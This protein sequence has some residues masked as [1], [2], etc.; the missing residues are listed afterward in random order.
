M[1]LRSRLQKLRDERFYVPVASFEEANDG[2]G[3]DDDEVVQVVAAKT[4][5]YREWLAGRP[6]IPGKGSVAN[7]F[8]LQLLGGGRPVEVLDVG[9]ACGGSCFEARTWFP[10]G[11]RRWHVVEMPEMAAAARP[12]EDEGLRFFSDFET[13]LQGFTEPPIAFL[14]GCLQYMRDPLEVL[15]RL[16]SDVG[17]LWITRTPLGSCDDRVGYFR[18]RTR[19]VDHGPGPAPSGT[20]DRDVFLPMVV[21]PSN[22]MVQR[23]ASY[24]SVVVTIDEGNA[25]AV[26]NTSISHRGFAV[27]VGA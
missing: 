23:L 6:P 18:Q 22:Q 19:L 10:A 8:A 26:G 15:D 4:R 21:L 12:F 17:G 3:Y 27:M 13:A 20:V 2:Q 1:S 7:L 16:S 5:R 11:V 24:G 9:G 25:F 14:S